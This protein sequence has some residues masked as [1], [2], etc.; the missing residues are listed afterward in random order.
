MSLTLC[1]DSQHIPHVPSAQLNSDSYQIAIDSC[2]L[3]LITKHRR[4][5]I[6]E[7]MPCNMKI[8][9]F[10]RSS[11]VKWKGNWRFGLED[12]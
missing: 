8:Q 10:T 5:F 11:T 6:G 4:D 2:C 9:G 12:D 7:L 3:F 1:M